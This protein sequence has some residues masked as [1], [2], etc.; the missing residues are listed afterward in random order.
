MSYRPYN[1]NPARKRTN[2]CVIRMLCKVTNRPW[3]ENYVDL[4]SKGLCLYDMPSSNPVWASYLRDLGYSK[5]TLPD[6]CPDCYTIN[7]FCLDNRNGIFVLATGN[8]VV[9]VED[10]K[11]YDAW[12]SGDE[13][14]TSFWVKERFER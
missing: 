13:S 12:D 9:Y 11:Y 8:H 3:Q 6:T 14:P 5:H 2:D 4:A 10:G 1:P 7:D